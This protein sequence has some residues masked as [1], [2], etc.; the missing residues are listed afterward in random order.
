[1]PPSSLSAKWQQQAIIYVEQNQFAQAAILYEQ[2]IESAPELSH[3]WHLGLLLLLQGQEEEAQT[4]WLLALSE[5][6]PDQTDA[7]VAELSQILHTEAER[8]TAKQ[9]QTTAWAIRQHFR[10]L[11]P[12]NI[13]N[14]LH[15]VTLSIELN[16][17]TDSLLEDIGLIQ[18][19]A[20]P[21]VQVSI[22]HLWHVF[23]RLLKTAPASDV[24]LAFVE[25]AI[26]H[27][28]YLDEAAN[29]IISGI[30][31]F[32]FTAFEEEFAIKLAECALN[33]NP[34]QTDILGLLAALHHNLGNHLEAVEI[35]KF[36]YQH[37]ES[38]IEQIFSNGLILRGLLGTGG[39]WQESVET[40]NHHR[41]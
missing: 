10:E 9:E 41:T 22:E 3:Y 6:D 23:D 14:L 5:I 24:L 21:N 27:L 18:Q 31:R 4:T 19:L 12:D 8:R 37:S 1:M 33:I 15:I 29:S 26:V 2:A 20:Q 25:T 34:V 32:G 28:Q 40:A 11:C 7:A 39:L 13:E 16:L 38:L 30:L 35:A 17:L 36:R